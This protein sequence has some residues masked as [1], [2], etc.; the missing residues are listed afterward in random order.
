MDS[1]DKRKRFIVNV[2][3]WVLIVAIGYICFKYLIELIMPFVLAFGIAFLL[4]PIIRLLSRKTKLK[5][6]LWAIVCVLVFYSTVGVLL[7]LGAVKLTA[8]LETVLVRL[9]SLYTNTVAPAL[10]TFFDSLQHKI[11]LLDPTVVE[12]LGDVGDQIVGSLG[13]SLSNLS[14]NAV[15]V[16][17]GIATS[18]PGILLNVLITIIATFFTAADYPNITRFIVRQL[19]EKAADI[20]LKVKNQI[21]EI[22]GQFL[23]SYMLIMLITFFELTVGF[24]ILGIDNALAIALLI[25]LFD[26]LP[27]LGTGG[28][29]IPWMIINFMLGNVRLGAGLLVV[30]IVVTVVRNIVEPRIIGLKVGIHPLITLISMFVGAELFGIIGL[31]GLPITC[32]M[33][34]SLNDKGAIHLL[35]K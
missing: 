20:V 19:P 21:G 15:G 8:W 16:I 35:K 25:A 14:M 11:N 32:A 34:K 13:S 3:Y 27:I 22:I 12:V 1:I 23:R 5:W 4:K 2:L 31:F 28:I 9:P 26:I 33:I 7:G 18:V 30:Y 24:L 17:S 29:V 6:N 10:T